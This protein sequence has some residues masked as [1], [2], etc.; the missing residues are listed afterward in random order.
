MS[1]VHNVFHISML[2]RCAYNPTY[3]IDF[4][5]IEV[6]N[7]V[8]YNEGPV[9]VLHY[10]VKKLRNKE[11]SFVKIQ[12][13]HHDKHEASWELG[14]RCARSF[15]FYFD[16]ICLRFGGWNLLFSGGECNTLY[17]P[18]CTNTYM[19][20]YRP[21]CIISYSYT[22]YIDLMWNP[23]QFQNLCWKVQLKQFT[24]TLN[25][26][27]IESIQPILIDSKLPTSLNR[28][29]PFQSIQP[30]PTIMN[31]FIQFESIQ[32]RKY[33]IS[34][35]NARQRMATTQPTQMAYK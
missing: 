4:S 25:R 35:F 28:F 1:E 13:H 33:P 18:Y 7:N 21:K 26:F 2:R 23:I 32:K 20:L 19:Y 10:E 22:L 27:I 24:W 30:E 31:R 17:F 34:S 15:C 14:Q 16:I 8:T 3:K 29:N 9:R 12:W 5:D 11:I 6:N